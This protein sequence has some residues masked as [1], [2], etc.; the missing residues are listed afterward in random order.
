MI[1]CNKHGRR[2][3][4]SAWL[5]RSSSR[6]DILNELIIRHSSQAMASPISLSPNNPNT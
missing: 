6:Y 5:Y 2:R 4:T 3:L 1:R